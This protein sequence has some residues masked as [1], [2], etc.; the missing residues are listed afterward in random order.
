MDGQ[1]YSAAPPP[2]PAQPVYQAVAA[3]NDPEYIAYLEGRIASLE[4]RLPNTK[5]VSPRFMQ[6]AWA[7]WGH[8]FVAQ[9]IIGLIVGA[10]S[11]VIAV[12]IGGLGMLSMSQF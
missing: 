4:S 2:Y 8:M 6:R 10:I 7:I 11:T 5:V 3:R 9:L 12:L 1:Q